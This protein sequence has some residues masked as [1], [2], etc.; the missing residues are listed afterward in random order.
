MRGF[1]K[2]YQAINPQ[3]VPKGSLYRENK[4]VTKAKF[5]RNIC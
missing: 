3:T 1:V 5:Y 4:E 2:Y